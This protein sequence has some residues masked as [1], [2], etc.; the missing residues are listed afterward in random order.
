MKTKLLSVFSLCALLA[1]TSCQDHRE[2]PASGQLPTP[3]T[4]ASGLGA[5]IGLARDAKGQIWVTE[6]GAGRVS[7]ITPDGN[8]YPVI[9]GFSV[10]VSPENTPD[11]LNHLAY[12]D[13]MLYILHGVDDKLYKADV[14]NFKPGDPAM[15]VSQLSSE[16]IGQFVLNYKFKE[17]TDDS[18]LYNLTF[19]PNGDLYI[20]DAA[21]NAIIRRTPNGALSVFT[22]LANIDNPTTVGPP[23]INV[24]PTSITFDGDKFLVTTLIG[25]PFPVG[26]ARI[27][28][29]SQ[30]GSVDTFQEGY[31]TM[32]DLLLAPDKRIITLSVGEFGPQGFA[33]NSG[34][35]KQTVNGQTTTLL[36][37]LNYPTSIIAGTAANTYY[38]SSLIDGTVKKITY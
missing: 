29:I 17:D 5:P 33:Q 15:T 2:P 37:G 14:S 9:T 3:T 1:A 7:V 22:E 36:T 8:K 10:T 6:A 38:V 21:A 16:P 11:G 34:N 28:K 18:N 20:T 19:A 24:V 30:D 13:G 12:K 23:K 4:L 26:K 35:I 31:T 25:F 32:V 27:Y